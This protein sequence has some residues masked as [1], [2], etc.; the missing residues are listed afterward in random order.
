M[1]E[2]ITNQFSVPWKYSPSDIFKL[3]FLR[4][5]APVLAAGILSRIPINIVDRFIVIFGGY[6]IS[7][8]FRKWLSAN[9]VFN[10][11]KAGFMPKKLTVNAKKLIN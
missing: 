7:L 3:G 2:F 4:H 6:G 9:S 11:P 1:I 8:I 5:N 10:E